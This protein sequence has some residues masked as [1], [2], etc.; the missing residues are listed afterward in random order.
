MLNNRT[1][2]K[3][4]NIIVNKIKQSYSWQGC[5]LL[6]SII[7]LCS[8]YAVY[9][10]DSATNLNDVVGELKVGLDTL[11]VVLA[12]VLVIFMNAGFAMLETG[13]CRSKNAV[14]MLSKNLIVFAISTIAFWILGFGLMFGDGNGFIGLQGFFLNGADNSPAVGEAYQG[15]YTSLS[16]AGVPLAAKFLFQVALSIKFSKRVLCS[17]RL[18]ILR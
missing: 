3:K 15:V 16:W 13:F 8:S 6:S 5:V 4:L 17:L 7:L 2:R 11:W 14:N 1:I 12:S 9:A 10:Q 18:N